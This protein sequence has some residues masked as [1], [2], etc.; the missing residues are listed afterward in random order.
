VRVGELQIGCR[1]GEH[2]TAQQNHS[3]EEHHT[4]QQNYLREPALGE[5]RTV[6]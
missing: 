6:Q 2:H 4:A 1:L 5:R 3:R